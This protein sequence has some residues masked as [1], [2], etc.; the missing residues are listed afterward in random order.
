MTPPAAAPGRRRSHVSWRRV[1]ILLAAAAP[2][3]LVLTVGAMLVWPPGPC[4]RR[5][6][7]ES[8]ARARRIT[9]PLEGWGNAYFYFDSAS[10]QAAWDRPPAYRMRDGTYVHPRPRKRADG[11]EQPDSFQFFSAGRDGSPDTEDDVNGWES[12]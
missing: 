5:P 10:Y 11:F 7:L 2:L 4:S 1:G 6:G 3:V 8:Q 12:R 9:L